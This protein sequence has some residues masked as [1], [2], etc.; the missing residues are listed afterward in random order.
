M[1]ICLDKT[2][3]LPNKHINGLR[4]EKLTKWSQRGKRD[5][6]SAHTDMTE[7]VGVCDV[8]VRVC[9]CVRVFGII[10]VNGREQM[11]VK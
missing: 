6:E 2:K 10:S 1:D 9:V 7:S 8:C 4:T 3:T 11:K 5:I